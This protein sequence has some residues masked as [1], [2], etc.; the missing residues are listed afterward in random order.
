MPGELWRRRVVAGRDAE[1]DRDHRGDAGDRCDDAHHADLHP[2][3]VGDQPEHAADRRED[4]EQDL[5]AG[6]RVAADRHGE[7]Q[8][9]HAAELPPEEHAQD[10][11]RPAEQRAD[12]VGDAPR[13]ARAEREQE[14]RQS[15]RRVWATASSWFAW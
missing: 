9:E 8:R 10:A 14:W 3:V 2:A 4:R 1:D 12:E 13:E 5:P 7:R 11:E 15:T 6:R